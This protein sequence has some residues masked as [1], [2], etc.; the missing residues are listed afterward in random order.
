MCLMPS[1]P[2]LDALLSQTHALSHKKH[3]PN[4]SS[5]HKIP[6]CCAQFPELPDDPLS[7]SRNILELPK[8]L[9]AVHSSRKYSH[10]LYSSQNIQILCT[11]FQN[12]RV[13]R[14][15]PQMPES[16]T[17]FP[18]DLSTTHSYHTY[19]S[20]EHRSSEYLSALHC[21]PKCLRIL[22]CSRRIQVLLILLQAPFLRDLRALHSSHTRC[23]IHHVHC[24]LLC[25]SEAP[26]FAEGR[27][28]G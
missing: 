11:V 2:H 25:C 23:C 17:Q 26:V 1:I 18:R 27:S 16:F 5:T 15:V 10:A 20:A 6:D 3:Q 28:E 7:F 8:Y 14:K 19:L 21:S 12:S 9:I 4:T 13:P 22:H 24:R